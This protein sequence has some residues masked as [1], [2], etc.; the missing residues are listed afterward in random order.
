MNTF[1]LILLTLLFTAIPVKGFSYT[2]NQIVK[3]GKIHYKVVS[4]TKHTLCFLG[5]D[6]SQTGNLV[7]PA[8][9][10]DVYG[11][12]FTV[13]RAEYS[14]FYFCKYITSIELPET[15]KSIGGYAFPSARL[16]SMNIP[17]SMEQID[18][19]AWGN[20][21]RAPKFTVAAGSE[22]FENDANGVL[23]SKGGAIL[24]SVPSEISLTGGKYVIDSRVKQINKGAFQN[25]QGL[26][27]IVFPKN[28]ETILYGYPT[29]A[30]TST[31]AK[32]E[33][34]PG[35]KNFS[36]KD[37]VLFKGTSLVLYPSS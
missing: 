2:D 31:L 25:V 15:M 37:G 17:K 35:A 22:Y 29:I 5:V 33:I 36:V 11:T 4:G 3:F 9:V 18:E 1:R 23:Y 13:V 28:L 21:N 24:H 14:P 10:T 8:N 6:D 30:P 19:V 26:T 34:A 7:I 16:K 27:T 20:I 32:C 12:I